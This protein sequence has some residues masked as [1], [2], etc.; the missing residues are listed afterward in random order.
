M[1]TKTLIAAAGLLATS[2][3]VLA[4]GMGRTADSISPA[5]L[6]ARGTTNSVVNIDVTGVQSFDGLG[7]ANTVL[8]IDLA[9]ALGLGAGSQ[10]TM[11]SVGWDVTISTFGLSWLS[12]ASIYFDDNIAPDL[13][14]LFLTPGIGNGFGGTNVNFASA[15][16]IDFSDNA[17]PNI[18]LPNGVLRIEFFEGFVDDTLG[19]DAIWDLGS[20]LFVGVQEVPAPGAAAVL[21]LAGLAGLRR[22]R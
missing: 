14:G 10:V 19:A 12:E 6:D 18:V 8:E 15:G 13:S 22:R 9:S 3:A 1:S 7:G 21:G 20:T 2:G 16:Q 17:I 11:T 4:A 5:N